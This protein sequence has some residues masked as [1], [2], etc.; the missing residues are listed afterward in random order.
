MSEQINLLKQLLEQLESYQDEVG[1]ADIKEFSIYL[2]DKVISDSPAKIGRHFDKNN[3]ARYKNYPEVE[4][5]TLLINLNRFAKHYTKKAFSRSVI[6]TIDE[7]GFLATLLREKSLLKNELIHRHLLETSSGSEIIKRLI[8]NEL[9]QELPDE[10]D[11]RAKRVSLTPKGENEILNAFDDMH[12]VSE[13]IIGNLTKKEVVQGLAIFNKL[14]YFHQHIHERDKNSSI[15]EL[16]KKYIHKKN[17][18]ESVDHQWTWSGGA[19]TEPF[20]D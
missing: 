6:K 10:K 3:Y 16:H 12:Q 5:F 14:G 9:V 11:K 20:I 8:K 7:F 18:E 13:I 19:G 4:F 17:E 15:Q 1:N 2:K